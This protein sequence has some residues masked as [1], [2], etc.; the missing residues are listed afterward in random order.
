MPA[1]K[2]AKPKPL[3]RLPHWVMRTERIQ[4]ELGYAYAH[5]VAYHAGCKVVRQH[6]TDIGVDFSIRYIDNFK[7]HEVDGDQIDIQLKSSYAATLSGNEIKYEMD[8][9]DYDKL[10]RQPRIPLCLVLFF[11]PRNAKQW[12]HTGRD[13]LSLRRCA[14]WIDMR[15]L[16]P[17]TNSSSITVPIPISQPFDVAALLGPIR[18]LATRK[19]Q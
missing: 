9:A 18:N 16:Q 8:R 3:Q 13:V 1:R 15:G 17:T 5:A 11:M 19:V 2:K 7:G 4:E 6:P 12:V 10:T 14:Y